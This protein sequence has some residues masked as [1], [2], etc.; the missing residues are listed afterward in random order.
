M[1]EPVSRATV[2]AF[3]RAYISRDPHQIGATLDDAVEWHVTGPA[4]AISICGFWRGKD[5]VID[6]FA[7]LVPQVL[8]VK[9]IDVEHLLIDGDSSAMFG[10][11]TSLLHETGRV[12]SHRVAQIARFRDGKVVY[13]SV[14]NDSFDAAEQF[15]GRRLNLHDTGSEA[16]VL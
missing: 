6:R 11:I 3:Y 4:E 13:F 5:A 10:R 1:T 7:R 12:I 14:M 16:F 9:R 15:L 8:T 2:E